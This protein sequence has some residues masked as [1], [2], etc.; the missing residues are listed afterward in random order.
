MYCA[1]IV[2]IK[3]LREHSN[4]DRLLCTEVF[5]NNV[6]VSKE[7]EE[8]QKCIFFPVDGRLGLDFAEKNN[9]IRKKDGNGNGT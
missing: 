4:A 5:G 2:E 7:Y 1:Y 8:R 9:L 3:S 6:I